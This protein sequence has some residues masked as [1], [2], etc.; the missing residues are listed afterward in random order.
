MTTLHAAI[1]DDLHEAV[2]A[3]APQ[4]ASARM[5]QPVA[6]EHK[7]GSDAQVVRFETNRSL[8]MR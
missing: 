7:P 3:Q 8:M 4:L 1:P 5:G 6:V 2:L